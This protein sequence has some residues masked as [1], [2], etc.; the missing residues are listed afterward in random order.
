MQKIK[1]N[2]EVKNEKPNGS[3]KTNTKKNKANKNKHTKEIQREKENTEEIYQSN[4]IFWIRFQLW[5]VMCR[6]I[7]PHFHTHNSP[8]P[9]RFVYSSSLKFMFP[10]FL[11]STFAVSGIDLWIC[12]LAY[13]ILKN[14]LLSTLKHW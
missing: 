6:T 10:L 13:G 4:F 3:K 7:G 9:S 8:T 12:C 14:I 11:L 1:Q 2:K 5:V